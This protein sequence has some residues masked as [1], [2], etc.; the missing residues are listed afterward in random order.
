MRRAWSLSTNSAALAALALLLLAPLSGCFNP[1][2]PACAFSCTRA[3][4][5]CPPDFTCE[6]DGLC[7]NLAS[8]G[9]CL[10]EPPDGAAATDG[11][12]DVA[13]QGQ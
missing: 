4:H 8:Q 9:I 12:T 10:I 2:K 7:H 1:D 3:P 11:D 13:D 6:A 5:V